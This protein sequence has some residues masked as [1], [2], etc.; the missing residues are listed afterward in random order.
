MR[1]KCRYRQSASPRGSSRPSRR[2]ARSVARSSVA[3]RSPVHR[4]ACWRWQRRCS[5]PAAW[6]PSSDSAAGHHSCSSRLRLRRLRRPARRIRIRRWFG[7]SI[8]G[9][10]RGRS[11]RRRPESG[12]RQA[13]SALQE[14]DPSTGTA[15]AQIDGGTWMFLEGADLWVQKGRGRDT[16]AGR[17]GDRTGARAVRRAS[18][19]SP[20]P[21][22]ATRSGGSTRTATSVRVDMATGEELASIDV[23]EEPKQIVLAADA[24]WVVCDAGNALVRI[25]PVAAEVTDTIDVG[26]GPVELEFGFD[27]LW[28]RNRQFELVRIDP[29]TAEV[30]RDD[31]GLR[32]EPFARPV[33]RRRLRMGVDPEPVR[34]GGHRSGHQF[35]RL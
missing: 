22:M 10:T 3:G 30:M 25:D 5:S 16:G 33:V 11:S 32:A 24:V 26:D 12:S 27:S 1:G 29:E 4:S 2:R 18:P 19:A 15:S 17:P 9:L 23:P 34:D 31:R 8:S 28:V 20:L 14:I 13:T 7:R 35:D 6:R 21:R